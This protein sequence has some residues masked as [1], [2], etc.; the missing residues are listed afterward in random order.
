MFWLLKYNH[1]L[2][3]VKQLTQMKPN[4][5]MAYDRLTACGLKPSVQRMAIM[6]YLLT[7]NTHPTVEDVFKALGKKIPTL[8][9]TTVYN[10]LRLFSENSA[11]QMLTI[12]DRH[13]CYDGMIEPHV[14]FFCRKCGRILDMMSVDAPKPL[15]GGTVVDGNVVD[16]VQLYYKGLCAECAADEKKKN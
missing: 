12:D 3:I 4:E 14:H 16:E 13:V 1:Y 7:H 15:P 6:E 8:S 10:T 11:A 2:C 5:K 9:K